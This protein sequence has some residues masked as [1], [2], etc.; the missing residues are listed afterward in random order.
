MVGGRGE[1]ERERKR[2]HTIFGAAVS[3]RC[4]Q[5][6]GAME[7]E[8]E[9]E[10]R[11]G[12]EIKARPEKIRV[13]VPEK[14]P[15]FPQWGKLGRVIGPGGRNPDHRRPVMPL[16]NGNSMLAGFRCLMKNNPE[17]RCRNE[18]TGA[19]P[20]CPRGVASVVLGRDM[21][22]FPKASLSGGQG[23]ADRSR[24]NKQQTCSKLKIQTVPSKKAL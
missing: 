10:G 18:G 24:P 11:G 19:H 23:L 8:K 20:L 7:K 6:K 9:K 14:G 3:A 4:C 13:F 12:V 21:V 1:R 5:E 17:S 16:R 2:K 22:I 15:T